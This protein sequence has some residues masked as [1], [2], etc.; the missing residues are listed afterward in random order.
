MFWYQYTIRREPPRRNPQRAGQTSARAQ[1]QLAERA[2]E[3][4]RAAAQERRRAM[5]RRLTERHLDAR[6]GTEVQVARIGPSSARCTTPVTMKALFSWCIG[7]QLCGAIRPQPANLRPSSSSQLEGW[8]HALPAGRIY[9]AD[10]SVLISVPWGRHCA[11]HTAD[12]FLHARAPSQC[13]APTSAMAVNEPGLGSFAD[14]EIENGI[15]RGFERT[16]IPLH[17]GE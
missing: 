16:D 10:F 9:I 15:D 4:T 2:R 5:N 17:L 13:R 11:S 8:A 12:L 7:G 3:K 14:H 6:F 1:E